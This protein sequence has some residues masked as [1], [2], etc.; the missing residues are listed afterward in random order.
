MSDPSEAPASMSQAAPLVEF[1]ETAERYLAA[2]LLPSRQQ[3]LDVVRIALEHGVPAAELYIDVIE[4]A[5]HEIGR[6]WQENRV[7]VAQE[8]IATAISQLALAELYP[9]LPRREQTGQRVLVACVEGE[10]HDLGARMVADLSE[11]E[12]FDVT[13]LGANVPTRSLVQLVQETLP[14]IVVLSVTMAF[15][16]PSLLDAVSRIREVVGDQP[17]IIAGGQALRWANGTPP[18][19]D[20]ATSR[21][22]A[23]TAARSLRAGMLA[24]GTGT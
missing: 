15:N 14:D 4:W 9:A 18:Q 2:Q 21:A 5:Q 12:G 19:I 6:L 11:M 17:R 8:H 7:T 22:D 24:A 16:L 20:A 10:L 13:L 1:K 23:L 3:A